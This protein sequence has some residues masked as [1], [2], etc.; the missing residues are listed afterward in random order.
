MAY[1]VANEKRLHKVHRKMLG[2]GEPLQYSIFRCDLSDQEKVMFMETLAKLI[3]HA[4]D[5]V[6]I[7]DTGDVEAKRQE[8][9][10]FVGKPLSEVHERWAIIV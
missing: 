7:V 3:N 2:F 9:I 4:E 5:R 8:Q 6:M 10:E 1:D